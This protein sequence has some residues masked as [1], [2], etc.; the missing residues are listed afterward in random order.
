MGSGWGMHPDKID[1]DRE[2]NR[3]IATYNERVGLWWRRQAENPAHANAYRKIAGFIEASYLEPPRLILDYACGAGNLLVR[4]HRRFP[5]AKLVGVDGS[6]LL[7]DLAKRR[8]LQG[9]KGAA[10]QLTLIQASLPNFDFP[11]ALADLV[12]FTFPNMVPVSAKRT[13]S[14]ASRMRPDDLAVA[15]YLARRRCP[16]NRSDPEDSRS[17]FT[18]LLRDRMVSMNMRKLLKPGGICVR[19]EYGNVPREEFPEL[20][21]LRTEFEEGSLGHEVG[22]KIAEQWFRVL[23]SRYCRSGVIEDVYHQSKDRRDRKGGFL[24]TVLRAL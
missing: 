4:L 19:V 21:L 1:F 22:G 18:A 15:R 20:E 10:A 2:L 12:L 6:S 3:G 14:P 23:A 7:L 16:V 5:V 13:G 8:F 17:I 9:G 24:I 11:C